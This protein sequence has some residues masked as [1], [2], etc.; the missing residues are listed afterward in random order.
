[1][2]RIRVI[3]VAYHRPLGIQV[4]INSFLLQT[5]PDW[6][7]YIIHDG[8][9]PLSVLHVIEE[10]GDPRVIFE[11]TERV[12]GD[13]G[14]PNRRMMINRTGGRPNEFILLTNDDNYY[15]PV[16]VEKM[17]GVARADT[18]IVYCDTVHSHFDYNVHKPK[19]QEHHID[20]GA[21]IVR[22]DVAKTVGFNY[23]HFSADGIYAEECKR[24]C[25]QHRLKIIYIPKPLFIHN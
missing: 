19:L 13:C 6:E 18:G 24:Y 2:E 5:N 23:N 17:L 12:N 16:F 1:M 9:A 22:G 10:C 21:F 8:I 7:L 4:L 20:I 14:H 3:S 25:D 11:E 15:V